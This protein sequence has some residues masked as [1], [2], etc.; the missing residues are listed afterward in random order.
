MSFV[1]I[2]VFRMENT[3]LKLKILYP[4]IAVTQLQERFGGL[5]EIIN[6]GFIQLCIKP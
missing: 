1:R 3:I 2:N 4:Y 5:N 6:K